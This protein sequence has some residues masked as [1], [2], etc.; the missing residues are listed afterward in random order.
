[1]DFSRLLCIVC[2]LASAF[3]SS[4]STA[5]EPLPQSQKAASINPKWEGRYT[6]RLEGET[7]N[8]GSTVSR[9]WDINIDPVSS[10]AKID[11][12]TWHAP[13]TC[14]GDYVVQDMGAT[15]LFTHRDEHEECIYSAPQFEMKKQSDGFYV[16]GRMFGGDANQWLRLVKRNLRIDTLIQ[17][18]DGS[19][20]QYESVTA[21]IVNGEKG[22]PESFY[23]QMFGDKPISF[24]GNKVRFSD[25]CRLSFSPYF[26]KPISYYH[27]DKSVEIYTALFARAGIQMP[28]EL[29]LLATKSPAGECIIEEPEFIYFGNKLAFFYEDKMVIYSRVEGA[30]AATSVIEKCESVP[31][32]GDE[33]HSQTRCFYPAMSLE[34]TYK[35]YVRSD[36]EN[37]L[38]TVKPGEDF[39]IEKLGDTDSVEYTWNGSQNLK[40]EQNFPGGITEFL[41]VADKSGTTVTENDYPD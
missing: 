1:M 12:T 28:D 7:L 37:L 22:H 29:T 41:F 39:V 17:K 19:S 3:F 35:V 15:L 27:S 25:D 9:T 30:P 18:L 21:G 33:Y 4:F 20:W 34:E 2:I 36:S 14:R 24:V 31:Q 16:K 13:F 32:N 23:K 40:I 6:L 5:R 38:P 10:T 11:I 26:Q 8:D